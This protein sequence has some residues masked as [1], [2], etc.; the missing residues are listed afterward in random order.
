MVRVGC[1]E[2][3]TG[4]HGPWHENTLQRWKMGRQAPSKKAIKTIRTQFL[5]LATES[6]ASE[7]RLYQ[8]CAILVVFADP[9]WRTFLAG[10]GA[11][12]PQLRPLTIR[13]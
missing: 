12:F 9:G 11:H 13:R 7:D 1:Y 8:V 5:Q 2:A 3:R 6:E 10:V 4:A